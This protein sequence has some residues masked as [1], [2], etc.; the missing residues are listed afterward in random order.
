MVEYLPPR[1]V[2]PPT[3]FAGRDHPMRIVTR[4]AAFDSPSW[5]PQRRQK[6]EKLFDGL[7]PEWH[8]K[9]AADRLLPLHDALERGHPSRG[10]CLELGCGT[11]PATSILGESFA[12]VLALD[13]SFEMLR[14]LDSP[15][16][17]RVRADASCLPISEPWADSIILM[18]MLLFPSEVARVLK[19]QGT[20]VWVNSRG[21]NT[22]IH[23]SP[24]DLVA[25]LPGSWTARAARAG[26]GLWAVAR[27]ADAAQ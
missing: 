21:E 5:T 1:E 15:E 27:R 7:A 6:V 2:T 13:L 4:E 20:I 26:E 24:E 10:N 22:P 8:Q 19:P 11:G 23:L 14:R 3:P 12:R 18:N 17:E 16:A 9:H 25:A